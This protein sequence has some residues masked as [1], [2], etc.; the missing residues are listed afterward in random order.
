MFTKQ[1][2]T[3]IYLL[4]HLIVDRMLLPVGELFEI[5]YFLV[6]A[7]IIVISITE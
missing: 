1:K 4:Q 6:S 3:V 7:F 5:F 2:S